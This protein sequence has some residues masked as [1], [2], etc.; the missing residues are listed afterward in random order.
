M[1]VNAALSESYIDGL[2]LRG[3]ERGF[4]MSQPNGVLHM[5]N[6]FLYASSQ[7]WLAEPDGTI[8]GFDWGNAC[9]LDLRGEFALLI[10]NTDLELNQAGEFEPGD[11]GLRIANVT[12]SG[13]L[14]LRDTCIEAQGSFYTLY[15][16]IAFFTLVARRL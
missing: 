4:M 7:G 14:G 12:G 3:T 5:S 9:P 1:A 8:P 15:K 13:T 6:S 10:A 11:S 2:N 16:F